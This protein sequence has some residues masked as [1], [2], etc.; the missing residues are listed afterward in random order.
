MIKRFKEYSEYRRNK[1]LAKRELS[2]MAATALPAIRSFLENKADTLNFIQ[3]LVTAAKSLNGEELIKLVL[4]EV[5]DKLVADQ[6]RLIEILQYMANMSP[7]DIQ[8]VVVHSVVETMHA[9]AETK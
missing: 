1:K 9:D 8:K 2:I 3:N 6:T 5:A 7:E 4:D